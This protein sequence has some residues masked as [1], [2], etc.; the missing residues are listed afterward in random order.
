MQKTRY[1][2]EKRDVRTTL[3]PDVLEAVQEAYELIQLK[4]G[5]G[6]IYLE[7][8][9]GWAGKSETTVTKMHTK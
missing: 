4:S 6:K 7:I 1:V 3:P 2:P 8:L 9:G 5:Y